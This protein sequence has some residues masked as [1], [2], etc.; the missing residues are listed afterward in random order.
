MKTIKSCNATGGNLTDA[1]FR[2]NRWWHTLFM[3]NVHHLDLDNVMMTL[4]N[5]L[6]TFMIIFYTFGNMLKPK[7]PYER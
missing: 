2:P 3:F 4:C 6:P 1:K 5:I 7:N